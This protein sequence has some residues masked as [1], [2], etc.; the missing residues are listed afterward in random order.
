MMDPEDILLDVIERDPGHCAEYYA[1][2]CRFNIPY[3]RRAITEM[4][5]TGRL[6]YVGNSLE[7]TVELVSNDS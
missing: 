2:M 4:L 7:E 6:R 5:S 3:V 1:D